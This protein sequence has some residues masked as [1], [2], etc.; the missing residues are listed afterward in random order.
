MRTQKLTLAMLALLLLA[1]LPKPAH[2]LRVELCIP[3]CANPVQKQAYKSDSRTSVGGVTT[4]TFNLATIGS[5]GGFTFLPTNSAKPA[6]IQA[7]QSGSVEVVI[8]DNVTVVAPSECSAGAPC[9]IRIIGSGGAAGGTPAVTSGGGLQINF[10]DFPNKKLPGGYPAGVNMSGFFTG[11]QASS[12]GDSISVT[13][14]SVSG[15]E[16][17]PDRLSTSGTPFVDPINLANPG[18]QVSLPSDCS[19]QTGCVFTA[20]PVESSFFDYMSQTVQH[21]CPTSAACTP[22]YRLNVALAFKTGGNRVSLPASGAHSNKHFVADLSNV[23]TPIQFANFTGTGT[24]TLKNTG[25]GDSGDASAT[26]TLSNDSNGQ[27]CKDEEVWFRF[28]T[29]DRT[30]LSKTFPAGALQT[31]GSSGACV[32]PTTVEV[33]GVTYHIVINGGPIVWGLNIDVANGNWGQFTGSVFLDFRI[34][35]DFGTAELVTTIK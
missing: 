15:I 6:T 33:N 23:T 28:R 10:D 27:F 4:T 21:K 18:T 17:N 11:S 7:Q 20:F 31:I 2:A 30:L 8:F 19:G 22:G 35:N 5:F 12:G 16:L 9:Q 26:F 1:I 34:G 32:L 3:D 14:M 25:Q 29:S 13:G 24:F